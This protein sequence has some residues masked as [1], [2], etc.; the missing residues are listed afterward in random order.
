MRRLLIGPALTLIALCALPGAGEA[1]GML[2]GI[3][4]GGGWIAIPIEAGSGRL[5]TDPIPTFG[6]RLDGCLTV[7][8]GHSG[9]WTLDARDVLTGER[10]DAVAIPGRGVRF[11]YQ[12]GP[13]A[14]ADVRVRWTEPRDTVLQVWVGLERKDSGRDPCEPV[15]GAGR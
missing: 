15:Y 3:R 4:Q 14:Q 1:Q 8:G 9:A 2:Q 12:T 11:S 10:L 5:T 13:R 6:L 7:W